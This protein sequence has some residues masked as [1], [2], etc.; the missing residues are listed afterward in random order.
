MGDAQPPSRPSHRW[1][2]PHPLTP[3]PPS[4]TAPP[5]AG[6]PARYGRGGIL[7]G[8]LHLLVLWSFAVAQPLLDLLG[9]A[10]EFFVARQ[11]TAGDILILTV[12]VILA[13]PVLLVLVEAVA[14]RIWP[15]LQQGLHLAFVGILTAAFALQVL[16]D[17]F[18]GSSAVLI[19]LAL[20]LGAAAAAAYARTRVVPS[21]LTV[22][23][24]APAV[25]AFLFLVASPVS[26]LVFRGDEAVA[27]NVTV[28]GDTPVV[29]ILLD[30]FSGV[31]L[32][33]G[34]HRIDRARL[35]SFARLAD[36]ATWYRNATSVADFTDRAVPAILTGE[37]PVR[38]TVPTASD[39]P[40]SLFTFL[41]RSYDFDVKEPVTD[42]CPRRLCP[43]ETAERLPFR[44]RLHDLRTDLSVVYLHLLLPDDLRRDLAPID[45]SFGD[46][47]GGAAG[48]QD[49]GGDPEGE[50]VRAGGAFFALAARA[51][52]FDA[53]VGRLGRRTTKPP[54]SFL[55]V[56]LP[57]NPYD[58][59]PDGRTYPQTVDQMPGLEDRPGTPGGRWR[60]DAALVGEAQERYLLQV[61]YADRLL[62]RAISRL[63]ATGIYDRALVVVMADH[64]AS[65]TPGTPHRAV[66]AGNAEQI[67]SIPLFVKAPGQRSGRVDDADVRAIDVLPTVASL[68]HTRLPWDVDGVRAGRAGTRPVRLQA[69]AGGEVSLPFADFVRRR[70]AAA[71]RLASRFRLGRRWP[72]PRPSPD[73]DLVGGR[74]STLGAAVAGDGRFELNDPDVF[75]AVDPRRSLPL[76]VS[77]RLAGR[78]APG[79]R[80]AVA[81]NGRVAAVVAPYRDG[82]D[83]RFAALVEP[84]AVVRGT[85]RVELVRVTG[86]GGGRRFALLRS[87]DLDFRLV[88]DGARE[89]I[90]DADGRRIPIGAG[91]EGSVDRSTP[92]LGGSVHLVGWAGDTDRV[93]GAQR[94][95]VFSGGRFVSAVVPSDP[96]P[97]L[98]DRYGRGLGKAGFVLD[99]TPSAAP[100]GSAPQPLRV[101]AVLDGRASPVRAA[102]GR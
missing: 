44:S 36:D 89:A 45:R 101:F 2:V 73:D 47:G 77:G 20:A 32:M 49:G 15:P 25:F 33:D 16:K 35:P 68:L 74:V 48:G 62:G 12:A 9:D 22:L 14:R 56:E 90:L 13:V 29:M 4:S 8:G 71:A 70:D 52:Q 66:T 1:Y 84:R 18:G 39:H 41:G 42:I 60:R 11:N 38:G 87:G 97:D 5:D 85:N 17:A 26:D 19:T 57:H 72:R 55:H 79:E 93:R 43:D 40:E 50:R 76:M 64:G 78:E 69:A 28:A 81:L 31:A 95:V 102:P 24:P 7:L 94:I 99:A 46:F 65:F 53:F 88:R 86:R 83:R 6:A 61:G 59:V 67:A 34:R 82:D 63:K 21:L 75:A 3:E 30:E 98:A 96:R 37:R 91:V 54:L 92:E 80:L 23:G 51:Q 10:P 100:R 27:S 58:R